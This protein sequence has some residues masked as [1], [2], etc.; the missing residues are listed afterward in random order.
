MPIVLDR[1]ST[2]APLTAAAV[3]IGDACVRISGAT[4]D[5]VHTAVFRSLRA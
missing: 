4:G 2:T 5:A 1:R 3:Q